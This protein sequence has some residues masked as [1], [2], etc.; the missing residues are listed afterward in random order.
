MNHFRKRKGSNITGDVLS[1]RAKIASDALSRD[2][3]HKIV[4]PSILKHVP[5]SVLTIHD[6]EPIQL[7]D[8]HL[9]ETQA[10]LVSVLTTL[11]P[12]K[13]ALITG[14][15]P[16]R[17]GTNPIPKLLRDSVSQTA[18]A[19]TKLTVTRQVFIINNLKSQWLKA[20]KPRPQSKLRCGKPSLGRFSQKP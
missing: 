19:V 2:T 14:S 11:I 18:S 16:K 6:Q 12:L 20:G 13:E 1:K 4:D 9:A 8:R 3:E 15:L 17:K 10:V 5:K 7:L